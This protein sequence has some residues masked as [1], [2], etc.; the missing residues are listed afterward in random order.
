MSGPLLWISVLSSVLMALG[1]GCL[2][3]W[4]VKKQYFRDL[5][6]AKYQV[7]WSDLQDL[8]DGDAV[9]HPEE[10]ERGTTE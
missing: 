3:V 1:G 2:F 6:D 4:A 7:F 8:V 5:E 10:H 9:V